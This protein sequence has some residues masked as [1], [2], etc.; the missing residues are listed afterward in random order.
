MQEGVTKWQ[1]LGWRAQKY[2]PTTF[3][4]AQTAR[5]KFLKTTQVSGFPNSAYTVKKNPAP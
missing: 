3:R 2:C 4:E 5:Q 1:A